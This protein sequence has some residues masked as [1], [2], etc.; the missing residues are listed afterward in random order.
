MENRKFNT[1]GS[2][3]VEGFTCKPKALDPNKPIMFFK[4]QIFICFGER[5]K[6]AYGRDTFILRDIL[7]ELLL[8]K[9][10]KRIKV[11]KSECFGACR[12][13]QVCVIFE[14]TNVSKN[15]ANNNIWLKNVHTYDEDRWRRLFLDLAYDKGLSLEL[16]EPIEMAWYE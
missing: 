9:G 14:N 15:I 1:M 5:C 7:K 11:S 6:R 4:T 2:E 16:Y 13:R 12:F 3:V 8:H 10:E